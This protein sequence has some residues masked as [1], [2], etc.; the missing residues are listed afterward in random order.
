VGR[1]SVGPCNDEGDLGCRERKEEAFPPRQVRG[2]EV[3]RTF[4][5]LQK[6]Y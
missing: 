1:L 4:G 5:P 3:G 2:A 6:F